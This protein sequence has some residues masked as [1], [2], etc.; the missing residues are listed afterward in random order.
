MKI[1]DVR[2]EVYLREQRPRR[3]EKDFYN[4]KR[5]V[6]KIPFTILRIITDD[7]IEGFAFDA[8]NIL[9]EKTINTIKGE[10]IGR[11]PFD[12][13]WIWQ[14]LWGLQVP[15]GALSAVDV[16][17]WDI[18]GKALG[19]PIYKLMGAYRDKIKIYATS[20]WLPTVQDYVDEALDCQRRGIAGYKIHVRPSI[21]IEV[22]RAVR[23]AVGDNMILILDSRHYYSR[24]QALRM[25]KEVEKLNFY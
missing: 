11:D 2:C 12:R 13:E 25:G 14:R 20:Y 23:K 5:P 15:V 4:V 1:K 22:C 21:A 9:N 8:Q 17:L 19:Q 18:A 7:G 3:M 24:E 6:G 16:A 10:I